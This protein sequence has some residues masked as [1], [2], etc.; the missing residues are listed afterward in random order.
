MTS[1]NSE[2]QKIREWQKDVIRSIGDD[3]STTT[4]NPPP[5]R[6]TLPPSRLE[7]SRPVVVN[8]IVTNPPVVVT[9]VRAPEPKPSEEIS[10][11]AVIGTVVGATAGAFIAYA[12]VKGNSE[13]FTPLRAQERIT[14]RTIEAPIEYNSR[15]VTR[16]PIQ[17]GRSIHG[18]L[19][20]GD[21]AIRTIGPPLPRAETLISKS[22]HSRDSASPRMQS[23]KVVSQNGPIIMVDNEQ[24]SRSRASSGRHTIKPQ[25]SIH[26]TPSAPVTEVRLARNVPLPTRSQPSRYSHATS[27]SVQKAT[28]PL[29]EPRQNPLPSL[30]PSDSISQVSSRKSRDSGHSKHHHTSYHGGRSKSGRKVE[31][32]YEVSRGGKAGSKHKVGEMVDDVVN[33]IK[34]TSIKGSEHRSSGG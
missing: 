33:I 14:Y 19:A 13:S 25:N 27:A 22:E 34:G 7:P 26:A 28:P 10:T 8:Q 32:E 2:D 12:M 23:Y 5:A 24:D 17:N 11:Q 16:I 30:A 3:N 4:R 6:S 9:R 18:S 20:H 31:K 1:N 21:S 29:V 15:P